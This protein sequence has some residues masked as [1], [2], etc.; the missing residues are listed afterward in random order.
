LDKYK[1]SRGNCSSGL[2]CK[3]AWQID[4]IK[5]QEIQNNRGVENGKKSADS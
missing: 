3:L 4:Q 2:E 1:K 5:K